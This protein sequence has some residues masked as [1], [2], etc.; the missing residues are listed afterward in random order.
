MKTSNFII[1]ILSV[2]GFMYLLGCFCGASFNIAIW[3]EALRATIGAISGIM[4]FILT[5]IQ[6]MI[7]YPAPE[8]K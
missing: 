6:I 7:L 3:H 2:C 8:I 1:A 5:M 4:V